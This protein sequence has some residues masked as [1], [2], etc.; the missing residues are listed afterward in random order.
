[1]SDSTTTTT[2]LSRETVEALAHHGYG[3]EM[4][5]AETAL[6]Y[7]TALEQIYHASSRADIERMVVEVLGYEPEG[8]LP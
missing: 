1:M 2:R 4:R 7:M 5:L 6:A 3:Y 8:T